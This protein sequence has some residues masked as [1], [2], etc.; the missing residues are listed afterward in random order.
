[1]KK[2]DC[3][4]LGRITKAH[5]LKGEV[6]CYFDVNDQMDYVGLDSFFVEFNNGL[7]PLFIE[8][9]N[10]KK[11][12]KVIVR[13]EDHASIDDIDYLISK[14]LYLPNT[15]LPE[16]NDDQ[17]YY[18]EIKGFRVIDETEGDIGPITDVLEY[19]SQPLI[20]VD[21][22]GNELLFPISDE[23]IANVD[24]ENKIM[25]VKLTEGLLDIYR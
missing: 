6:Q 5:G 19:S 4:Y 18:H 22:N 8:N 2:E 21:F 10:L 12:G 25:N 23:V 3:Y 7:M 17:F 11:P 13:L 24:K 15:S 20:Q 16:L 1:M 9:I 14:G